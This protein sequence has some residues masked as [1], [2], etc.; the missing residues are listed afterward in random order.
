MRRV[1]K[2][3]TSNLIIIGIVSFIALVVVA[4]LALSN[5]P[6]TSDSDHLE[7]IASLP[8]GTTADGLP[9][10]GLEDAPV[11]ML[12]YED[13]GC[14]NCRNFYQTVEPLVIAEFVATDKVKLIVYTLA[15]INTNSLPGAE[16]VAC[17][18]DQGRFWEYRDT[19]YNNQGVN[20]F[21]R[22]NLVGFADDLGLDAGAFAECFDFSVHTQDVIEGSQQAFEFGINATPT[23][24]IN[25]QRFQG[26]KPYDRDDP[27]DPG[28]KQILEK[29]YTDAT[30]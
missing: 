1:N 27:A 19:L 4:L 29:A 21:N 28:V 2:Q 18:R 7:L 20:P 15:I 30:Q 25:N 22:N 5:R 16:G 23:F 11:T 10:L 3:R 24:F 12:L 17:A 14:P 26:V 13:L 6:T 8:Q 9:F